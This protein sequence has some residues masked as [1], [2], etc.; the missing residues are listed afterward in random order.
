M[1]AHSNALWKNGFAVQLSACLDLH[2]CTIAIAD[3]V[4]SRYSS[5][6]E[7]APFADEYVTTGAAVAG[8]KKDAFIDF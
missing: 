7:D 3:F 1:A 8:S 4:S 6:V 5:D 2:N